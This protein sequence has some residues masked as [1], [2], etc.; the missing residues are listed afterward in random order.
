[1]IRARSVLLALLLF[2]GCWCL[3]DLR[4]RDAA[5]LAAEGELRTTRDPATALLLGLASEETKPT[6]R[7]RSLLYAALGQLRELRTI[8]ALPNEILAVAWSGDAL[9][10]GDAGGRLLRLD[11]PYDGPVQH[12]SRE[13][14]AI[15]SIEVAPGGNRILTTS[16]SF[17][18]GVLREL[19]SGATIARLDGVRQPRFRADGAVLLGLG[20]AGEAVLVDAADGER[21][22]T[23]ELP[24]RR[25]VATCF[26][27]GDT[28][29]TATDDGAVQWWHPDAS[30]VQRELRCGRRRPASLS[31]ARSEPRVVARFTTGEAMLLDPRLP[32]PLAIL[33][34][35]SGAIAS[36]TFAGLSDQ[37]VTTTAGM[38]PTVATWSFPAGPSERELAAHAR[39]LATGT[40]AAWVGIATADGALLL[41]LERTDPPILLQGHRGAVHALA[42][43]E[44]QPLAA[45]AGPD[46][47]LRIWRTQVATQIA[48]PPTDRWVQVVTALA[49]T[50][51]A[52]SAPD[53]ILWV[54]T[55]ELPR[56]SQALIGSDER[57]TALA[58]DPSAARLASAGAVRE[59]TV[60][61]L[62]TGL[63]EL[64]LA[65]HR[66][67]VTCLAF[68]PDRNWLLS[69]SLD[70]TIQL[71]DAT[72]GA[73]LRTLDEHAGGIQVLAISPDGTRL[74]SGSRDQST[75]IWELPRGKE[76]HVLTG[77]RKAVTHLAWS[78]DGHL[79][80]SGSEDHRVRV[81]DTATGELRHR[82]DTHAGPILALDQ[83]QEPAAWFVASRD[84][85]CL[86]DAATGRERQV[87]RADSPLLAAAI[88]PS[89]EYVA[90]AHSDGRLTS[91]DAQSGAFHAAITAARRPIVW[92]AWRGS[93]DSLVGRDDE[94]ALWQ[95]PRDPAEA[96]RVLAPRQLT[97]AERAAFLLPD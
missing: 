88:D 34:S 42:V 69:G 59:I 93:G 54:H 38:V 77:H 5:R 85:A 52:A 10:A 89:G 26:A 55:L 92:L 62:T 18:P 41:D 32:E 67:L 43:H 4:E 73:A 94:G 97:R 29:V 74:A 61:D 35:E 20:V 40:D 87:F 78:R 71:W 81:Y 45:T 76:L 47:T 64:N 27:A 57:I 70:R 21:Q 37:V 19:H 75:R 2:A 72:T 83:V 91:W 25:I 33:Q 30:A 90:L 50:R 82:F 65:G 60:W 68:V 8:Q 24:G 56:S 95:W 48:A 13:E 15:A 17:G 23:L 63:A 9:L 49:G 79:L 6:A 14:D 44:A 31:G 3:S 16:G 39:L 7:A 84:R 66:D 11:P 36:G 51:L 28:I 53:Q 1:M 86:W 58:L 96:A 12:L 80:A 22:A 46:G